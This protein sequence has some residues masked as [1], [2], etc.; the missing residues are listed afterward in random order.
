M[1][2]KNLNLNYSWF[3]IQKNRFLAKNIW[4]F[5]RRSVAI[6][7]HIIN[8]TPYSLY[9]NG[10]LDGPL[11]NCGS[12]IAEIILWVEILN[13]KKIDFCTVNAKCGAAKIYGLCLGFSNSN[14]SSHTFKI[15]L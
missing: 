7:K 12:R 2:K 14:L 4:K 8:N 10:N 6:W 1:L 15:F 13:F 11:S 3:W 9:A 5:P